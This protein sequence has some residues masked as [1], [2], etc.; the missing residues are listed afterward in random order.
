MNLQAIVQDLVHSRG[1]GTARWTNEGPIPSWAHPGKCL[2][3]GLPG[4]ESPVAVVAELE[5]GLAP[6]IGLSGDLDSEVAMAE[7]CLD[8]LLEASLEGADYKPLP[9]F[10][11]IKVDVAVS[12]LESTPA[13]DLL[14]LIEQA[15]KKQ[16]ADMELFDLYRGESVGPGRKSLAFHVLLQSDKKTL[17]DKDEQKFLQRF[18]RLVSE[19]GGELRGT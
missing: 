4:I 12:V 13:A 16:V 15:G 8:A 5:P 6:A 10:P 1:C 9:R 17:T 18:E 14:A 3:L 19:A 2:F 11:G 7:L